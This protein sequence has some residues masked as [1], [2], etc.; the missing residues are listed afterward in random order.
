M[1]R[2]STLNFTY[3]LVLAIAKA[4]V[5]L[6]CSGS[7]LSMKQFPVGSLSFYILTLFKQAKLLRKHLL[8]SMAF[9]IE[10]KLRLAQE[11]RR[12]FLLLQ[13]Q[14]SVFCLDPVEGLA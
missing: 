13:A 9:V 6:T 5:K 3:K 7:R 1:Q 2:E 12:L 11:I 8:M 10:R 14:R 4:D